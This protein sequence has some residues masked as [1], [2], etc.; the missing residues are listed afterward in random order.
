MVELE[1]L[2][3]LV[4]RIDS[5]G[6]DRDWITIAYE[7]KSGRKPEEVEA[8]WSTNKLGKEDMIKK[9]SILPLLPKLF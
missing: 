9:V 8:K 6:Y 5:L 7:L 3:E 1:K 4:V 2:K